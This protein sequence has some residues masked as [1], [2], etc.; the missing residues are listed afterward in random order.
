MSRAV[1]LPPEKI[2]ELNGFAKMEVSAGRL[3]GAAW[4]LPLIA[5]LVLVSGVG[6]VGSVGTAASRLP[7]AAGVDGLLA[8]ALSTVHARCGTPYVATLALGLAATFLLIFYQHGHL[9]V[10]PIR[11]QSG[12]LTTNPFHSW[13]SRASFHIS[14]SSRVLGRPASDSARHS[15][16]P[17]PPWRF[18][19]R[20]C[21][22]RKS[23]TSGCSKANLPQ[24]RWPS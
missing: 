19:P 2:T 16:W 4:L 21:L 1:V 24:E 17:S 5:L 6:F 8:K 14:T 18:Y 22:P 12:R 13:L 20:W 7:F 11:I 9:C 15:D 10:S 3:L 23:P